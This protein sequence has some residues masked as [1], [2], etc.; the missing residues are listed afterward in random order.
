[1]RRFV[2]ARTLRLGLAAV[3]ATLA[4][5]AA[6]S[7]APHAAGLSY[8]AVNKSGQARIWSANADG[9]GRRDLGAGQNGEISPNGHYV[10]TSTLPESA[11]AI[12]R[13][14]GGAV[15]HAPSLA[16]DLVGDMAWSADSRYLAL[17]WIHIGKT[18][19]QTRAGVSV[20]SVP[21]GAQVASFVAAKSI[22][23]VSF[24]PGSSDRLVFVESETHYL[25]RRGSLKE[26][27][28]HTQAG[29]SSQAIETLLSGG[30]YSSP[31]WTR[32]GIVYDSLRPRPAVGF[33][34]FQ[35]MML[36]D[37]KV[38]QLSHFKIPDSEVGPFPVAASS[39]GKRL[40]ANFIGAFTS[41]A[42]LVDVV[43][44]TVHKVR[45]AGAGSQAQT[46]AYGIS[47]NGKQLLIGYQSS[48]REALPRGEVA[49]VPSAGGKLKVLV[50]RAFEPSWP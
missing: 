23:G 37:Q 30:R 14:G 43:S 49:T 17:T 8:T 40:V 3:A 46:T 13:T 47:A 5:P 16:T 48:Y 41:D 38:T 20:I 12:Y 21:S 2:G 27:S 4:I 10:A 7:A 19:S 22:S 50:H 18:G 6:A 1:M 45:V 9:G 42:Y 15:V 34:A 11:L 36:R 28:W 35:L 44:R 25:D 29:H 24:A 31:L 32:Y 33:P 26:L 39:S